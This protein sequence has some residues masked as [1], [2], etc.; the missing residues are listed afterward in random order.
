MVREIMKDE[1]FLAEASEKATLSGTR[2]AVRSRYSAA[3]VIGMDASSFSSASH[4]FENFTTSARKGKGGKAP[5]KNDARG[6]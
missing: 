1:V 6:G 4:T 2:A 5:A 3:F